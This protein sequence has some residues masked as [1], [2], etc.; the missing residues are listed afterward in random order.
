[1]RAAVVG[2][3]GTG[4]SALWRLARAGH[5]VTG[6]EQF[7]VGHAHGSSHGETRIIR[8][9]YPDAL[10][11]GLMAAGF[12]HWRE[13]EEFSGEALLVTCGGLFLGVSGDP[14]VESCA[15][16]LESGGVAYERLSAAETNDRFPAIHLEPGEEAVYQSEGGFL[17]AGDCV[18]ANAG[19]ARFYG[20]DLREQCPVR[21]IEARDGRAAVVTDAG[22]E[23]Y[24]RVIVTAGAWMGSMFA[25]LG[26][27]LTVTRQQIAYLGISGSA[28]D[29]QPGVMPVWIDAT[30]NYYGFPADSRIPGIKVAL[31]YPGEPVDPEHVDRQ[32]DMKTLDALVEYA[33]RRLPGVTQELTHTSV[34]LYTST[35]NEDFIVDA[36]PD[37][38]GAW[39][40]SG[41]SGHGFKFTQLLGQIAADLA[42][43]GSTPHDIRRFA[44]SNFV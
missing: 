41:C 9:T 26:L 21:R 30:T 8:Y 18:R 23:M 31:H 7:T 13:L 32:V 39:I 28:E 42:V 19:L 10:Y 37:I 34:C 20:A 35:P 11:S 40:V 16:A 14:N 4:S 43:D 1:M 6:Y 17:R 33:G 2:V 44:L 29:L 36:V 38:P 22:A 3:G 15:R 24:D 27:P 25:G 12:R 5:D